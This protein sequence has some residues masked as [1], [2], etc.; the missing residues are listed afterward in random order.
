[1]ICDILIVGWVLDVVKVEE[2]NIEIWS[3]GERNDILRFCFNL[4]NIFVYLLVI[5]C[6]GKY[7][8]V[9]VFLKWIKFMGY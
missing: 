1:M 7:V 9:K 4:E 5:S 2:M 8:F 3:F 6:L